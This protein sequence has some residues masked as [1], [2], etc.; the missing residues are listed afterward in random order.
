MKKTRKIK[1]SGGDHPAGA[2]W[3]FDATVDYTGCTLEDVLDDTFAHNVVQL[4]NGD[5]RKRTAKELD[6]LV[7]A[8]GITVAY[9]DIKKGRKPVDRNAI[10]RKF[11]VETMGVSEEKADLIMNNEE[12]REAIAKMIEEI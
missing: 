5:L 2:E 12:K 7:A 6:E 4:Q 3:K 10:I 11:L 1:V 9:K 8:G